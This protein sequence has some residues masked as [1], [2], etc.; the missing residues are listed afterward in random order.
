MP[1]CSLMERRAAVLTRAPA[2]TRSRA[3]HRLLRCPSAV[4]V[5]GGK[6]SLVMGR[7]RP[8][9]NHFSAAKAPKSGLQFLLVNRPSA[10]FDPR[11]A[12][13]GLHACARTAWLHGSCVSRMLGMLA[14]CV[15]RCVHRD[16]AMKPRDAYSGRSSESERRRNAASRPVDLRMRGRTN[17]RCRPKCRKSPS[18]SGG[19]AGPAPCHPRSCAIAPATTAAASRCRW[20]VLT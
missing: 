17:P 12:H 19:T 15:Q 18:G 6:P 1:P 9:P 14:A 16:S 5:Q 11:C 13:L 2:A 4:Q 3:A 7:R 10:C 20:T 8:P